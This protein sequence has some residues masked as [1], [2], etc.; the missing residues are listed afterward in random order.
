MRIGIIGTGGIATSA[1][2]P[3]YVKA[4][5]DVVAVMNRTRANGERVARQFGIPNVYENVEEML[6]HEQLDAV[7]ICTPNALHKEQV[8]LALE[9]GCHVL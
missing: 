4:G 1:H 3:N 5:M 8:L 2:I 6:T 9:A 7:S